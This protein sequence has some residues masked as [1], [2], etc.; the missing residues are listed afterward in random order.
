M[1][2]PEDLEKVGE[3][4][5]FFKLK[6]SHCSSC[7]FSYELIDEQGDY[8]GNDCTI[9]SCQYHLGDEELIPKKCPLRN[10]GFYIKGELEKNK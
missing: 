8:L 2:F 1:L 7:P 4:V 3:E 9:S 6:I 10:K 5:N